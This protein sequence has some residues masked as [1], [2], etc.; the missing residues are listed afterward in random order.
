MKNKKEEKN[1]NDD[2][3]NEFIEKNKEYENK[4]KFLDDKIKILEDE[5]KKLKEAPKKHADEG[6]NS[7]AQ[8]KPMNEIINP[9]NAQNK[10]KNEIVKLEKDKDKLINQVDFKGNPQ[11]LK[12]KY[13]LTNKRTDSGLLHNF[14]DFVGLKDKIEHIIY[15]NKDNYNLDIMRVNDQFITNSLKGHNNSTTVI[16]Y[17][18][19]NNVEDYILSCDFDRLSIIWDIQNDYNQKYKI[20]S[21]YTGYIYDALLLFNYYNK[22]Y[23]LLSSS[24]AKDYSTLYEFK[25]NTPFIKNIYGTN[26]N[27]T[28]YM[29]PWLYKNK[30]YIIECCSNK[31]LINNIFE[32]EKYVI[33]SKEPEGYHYCGYIYKDNYLCVSDWD[34]NLIR[35]WDL[36]SKSIYKQINYEANNGCEIIP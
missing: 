34:N 7:D 23:I 8:K 24:K 6:L 31:I 29:I 35:I 22:D 13:Q 20:Q 15:N 3:R 30:Y 11:N 18:L 28:R 2:I 14:H 19:R 33:L 26:N 36:V 1:D 16:R 9:N 12:F 27:S 10:E 21:N 5:I 4:I 32:N 17:Y 25:D